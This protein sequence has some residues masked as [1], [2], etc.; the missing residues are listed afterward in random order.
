RPIALLDPLRFGPL[1]DHRNR[2]LFE[3]VVAGI[4]GY[5]NCIGVPTVGGEVQFAEV[6]ASNPTVNVMCVGVTSADRLVTAER[7]VHEGALLVLIGAA[8]GR[9][10][11]GGVSV[12]ASRPLEEDA[13]ESRPSVQIG[14]PFA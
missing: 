4:G 13:A 12:L 14:D 6:H 2:W 7:E 10:G 3:G 9:D 5:G 1:N 11:I 8:T